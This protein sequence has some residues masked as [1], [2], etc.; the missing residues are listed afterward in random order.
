MRIHTRAAFALSMT[1]AIALGLLI[2]HRDDAARAQQPPPYDGFNQ[3]DSWGWDYE[4]GTDTFP[5]D[6]TYQTAG[7]TLEPSEGAS[8]APIAA[9][10]WMEWYGD[11]DGT[12][13]ITARGDGLRAVVAVYE[14]DPGGDFIPSP[15]GGNLISLACGAAVTSGGAATVTLD[16]D[17]DRPHYIQVGTTGGTG[18]I[19]VTATCACAPA[20]DDEDRAW[21]RSIYL[22]AWQPSA[23]RTVDT[24]HA[25]L[26]PGEPRPCGDIGATAWFE[27]SSPT[28]DHLRLS[29][30]GAGADTVIAAYTGDPST[31]QLQLAG[32]S[33]ATGPGGTEHL[34]LE[35]AAYAL[36]YVQVGTRGKGGTLTLEAACDPNCPP[37]FDDIGNVGW[38]NDLPAYFSDITTGA[39]LEAGEPRPCGDIGATV[40]YQVVARGD[41]RVTVD[42]TGSDFDAVLAA[43]TQESASPPPSTLAPVAC[44]AGT[45][46]NPAHLALDAE[47]NVPYL[48]QAGG[49]SD[50]A[51]YLE[52]AIDCDPSPCPPLADDHLG[53]HSNYWIDVPYGLPFRNTYDTID[54]TNATTEPDEP[55]DC[56]NMGR[57]IWLP[58]Q[59]IQLSTPI[60]ISTEGSAFD[61][62]IAVYHAPADDSPLSDFRRI[63]CADG[64]A[65]QPTE[66]RFVLP[67]DSTVYIQ[68]GGRN[69]DGGP[70]QISID[71]DPAP[72]PPEN[73]GAGRASELYPFGSS[74]YLDTSGA[75]LEPGESQ[76][77]EDGLANTAW[78]RF[79]SA[80][81]ATIQISLAGSDFDAGMAVYPLAG[82]SSPP[83]AFADATCMSASSTELAFRITPK[84]TYYVQVGGRHGAT[85]GHVSMNIS[86][87]EGCPVEG[88]SPPGGI[89]TG[90]IYGSVSGPDTGSGGYLPRARR[91]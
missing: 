57:T 13:T 38:A 43:Y 51:G 32:C 31:F 55:L 3:R 7:A 91:P 87:V 74:W 48:I 17:R 1:L 76:P 60:R 61:A 40:W 69:S 35:N 24:S 42:A 5:L 80:W 64:A 46:E 41:T 20:N 49:H 65:S 63:A 14:L 21:D 67:A 30:T 44:D 12:L 45:R 89:G 2:A 6:G 58:I 56:G 88:L 59:S 53:A 28:P 79:N 73:D 50:A 81:D 83:G 33:D 71:C 25:T 15:P 39:T 68:V 82:Y 78:W 77:C 8:C 75:T 16:A 22:D 9:T 18:D 4:T 66:L 27:V 19:R 90:I 23:R 84:T 52:L 85:G 29:L 26:Q 11:R 86:C 72:C 36:Y 10:V 34:T 47:A 54:T 62:A 37:Y 70:L